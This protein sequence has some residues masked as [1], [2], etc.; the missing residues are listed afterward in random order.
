MKN[1]LR[2]L[3]VLVIAS[4]LFFLLLVRKSRV[5]SPATGGKSLETLGY[6][7]WVPAGNSIHKK[8]VTRYLRGESF[9]GFNLYNSRDESVASL[10]DMNGRVIHRWKSPEE[11]RGS[12]HHVEICPNGDLMV[13]IKDKALLRLD[14]QSRLK[15]IRRFRFHHDIA[16]GEN[17]DIYAIASR[18][19]FVIHNRLPYPVVF[20]CVFHLSS[21]GQPLGEIPVYPMVADRIPPDHF[22]RIYHWLSIDFWQKEVIKQ[23]KLTGLFLPSAP[24]VDILH[25]NSLEI[26]PRDIAGLCTKGDLLISIR[27]LDLIGIVDLSHEKLIW[28][29]GPGI[30]QKQHQPVLLDNANILLFDNGNLNRGFSRVLEMNP[31]TGEIVWE[32]RAN[33]PRKFFSFSRG[34]NQRLPNGN[35]LIT[36]SDRGRVFEVTRSGKIVWEFYNPRTHKKSKT[37]AAIYRMIRLWDLRRYPFLKKIRS[38]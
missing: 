24:P 34:G 12:W 21:A 16:I 38:H 20:D 5:T 9:A 19:K 22:Q 14:W 18:E 37:R 23:Q 30:I 26:I 6:L 28:S 7:T 25:T 31:F 27:E 35:T 33:P 36:E 15:W 29:W 32:Y 10:M 11:I 13:I 3:I 8:G 1:I 17:G 4:G 2:I